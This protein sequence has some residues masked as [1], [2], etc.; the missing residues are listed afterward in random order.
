[1]GGIHKI[2]SS[3]FIQ[4]GSVAH[5]KNGINITGSLSSSTISS[6]DFIGLET[7]NEVDIPLNVGRDMEDG[8]YQ[9]WITPPNIPIRITASGDFDGFCFIENH[10]SLIFEPRIRIHLLV[11]QNAARRIWIR[12]RLRIRIRIRIWT[13]MGIHIRIY[14]RI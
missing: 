4:S 3:L 10:I 2:T 8:T 12:I 7:S 11:V 13:R 9:E 14:I 1:M 6:P 5:F